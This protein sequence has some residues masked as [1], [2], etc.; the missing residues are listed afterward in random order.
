[1]SRDNTGK[2]TRNHSSGRETSGKKAPN[3]QF[4]LIYAIILFIVIIIAY[5]LLQRPGEPLRMVARFAATFGYLTIF[6]AI[7]SS[8]YMAK[9]RKI[10]GLPFLKAH[11]NLARIGILLILIHPLALAI[12][13][14]DFRIFL[15]VLY[16]VEVFL[17][18]GGRTALY[19]FLLAAGIAIY[20]KKYRN[21]KKVHYLH[22]LA[23][24]LV[25]AHALLIG[26]DFRLDIMRMLALVMAAAVTGVFIHKRSGTKT[27]PRK[28][29]DNI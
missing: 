13:A 11:H 28:N 17:A 7:L 5:I 3:K 1:M 16:P 21:W 19:L 8:E 24:L 22:Y 14:Q 6:I 29:K 4:Y 26:S 2:S 23:F 9:M 27:K 25:T 20:R 18:L 10:L 15:P 12:E